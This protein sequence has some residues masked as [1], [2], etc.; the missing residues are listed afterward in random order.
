MM[1]P[2]MSCSA[3]LA[4]Y[5]IFVAAFF[6]TGGQ[7]IIFSL[8]VI[9]ILV[10]I[11]TARLLRNSLVTSAESMSIMEMPDYRWPML[12][13]LLRQTWYRLKSFLVKAGILIVVLCVVI[14]GLGTP[15]LE[16]MG[17]F[18]TPLFAPIGIS[19]D[20]WPATISLVTGLLAKEAVVG[21]L[22]AFYASEHAMIEAFGGP[23]AAY[24]YLLFTL[25]YFPCVSVVAAIA[26]ELNLRWAMFSVV[27]S[28]G[29]AYLIAALFFQIASL[30]SWTLIALMGVLLIGFFITARRLVKMQVLDVVKVRKVLP[31]AIVVN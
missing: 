10:A 23:I 17:K 29:L 5:A 7:N 27:W 20:N 15:M 14:N 31:T 4:I 24:S 13:G 11:L 2:F 30:N 18:L 25:L 28:T 21:T 8:Y 22:N 1:T 16:A 3:R 26:K 6:P 19:A 9:G 12:R